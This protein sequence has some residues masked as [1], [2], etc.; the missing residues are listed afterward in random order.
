MLRK[1]SQRLLILDRLLSVGHIDQ[2]YAKRR[3]ITR[4][5]AYV[6]RLKGQGYNIVTIRVNERTTYVLGEP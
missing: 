4:L 2:A 5:P 1:R 3:G 6:T